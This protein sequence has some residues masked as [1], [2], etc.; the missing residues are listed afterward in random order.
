ML[1]LPT[2]RLLSYYK[3]AVNQ[4]PGICK[5]N[6]EWMAN[7]AKRLNVPPVGMRGGLLLDEMQI[8]EDLQVHY[9]CKLLILLKDLLEFIH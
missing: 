7:E 1:V 9:P 8:Q 2:G 6:L 5:D 4:E 3:N